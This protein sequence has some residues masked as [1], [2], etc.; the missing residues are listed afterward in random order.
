MQDFSICI[1]RSIP[2]GNEWVEWDFVTAVSSESGEVSE[3]YDL[4]LVKLKRLDLFFFGIEPKSPKL[5]DF[6]HL[7]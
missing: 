6:R 4:A 7:G 5:K 2:R 1:S 3:A